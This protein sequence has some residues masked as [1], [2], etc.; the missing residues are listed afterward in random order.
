MIFFSGMHDL[1]IQVEWM[2]SELHT[3]KFNSIEWIIRPGLH[4]QMNGFSAK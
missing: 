3:A 4:V 2:I 1:L